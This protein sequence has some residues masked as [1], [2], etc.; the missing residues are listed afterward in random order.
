MVKKIV[1][2]VTACLFVF[3]FFF[4]LGAL[5]AVL[6]EVFMMGFRLI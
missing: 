1:A 5:C 3:G 6:Y 4:I 2:F